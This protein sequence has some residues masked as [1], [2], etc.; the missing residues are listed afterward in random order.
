MSIQAKRFEGFSRD[1]NSPIADFGSLREVGLFNTSESIFKFD[2]DE[3]N[4]LLKLK[5]SAKAAKELLNDGKAFADT[6]KEKLN[7]LTRFAK[8][9]F[10]SIVDFASASQDLIKSYIDDIFTGFPQQMKDLI[11]SVGNICRDEALSDGAATGSYVN[12]PN[13]GSIGGGKTR[14]PPGRTQ[15][16]LGTIGTD[17]S[18]ALSRGLN[19]I[20]KAASALASLLSLGYN[21]NLCNVFTSV[22]GSVGI[23][24]KSI[25]T[26]ASALVLNKQGIKGNIRSALDI[27]KNDIGSISGIAPSAIPTTVKYMAKENNINKSNVAHVTQSVELAFDELDPTWR[28]DDND[29]LSLAKLGTQNEEMEKLM[30]FRRE[31][32]TFNLLDLDEVSEDPDVT[33]AA[34]YSAGTLPMAA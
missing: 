10:N 1:F 34:M 22:L 3:N 27:A 24:D 32:N 5:G 16:L 18:R 14:C 2:V 26:T 11:M 15:G 8:D 23:D 25:I 17:I 7:D 29:E 13:C 30:S 12:N 4:P 9:Q 19:A 33:F 20:K 6:V 28:R 31:T 21:A